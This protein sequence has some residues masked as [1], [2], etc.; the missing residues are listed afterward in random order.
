METN[1]SFPLSMR[2]PMRFCEWDEFCAAMLAC[3]C[4]NVLVG[5]IV[6]DG[7]G[8]C[9][10]SR[11]DGESGCAFSSEERLEEGAV[12]VEEREDEDAAESIVESAVTVEAEAKGEL[13]PKKVIPASARRGAELRANA[14][15]RADLSG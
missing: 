14:A 9:A 4:A 13:R 5:G 3:A 11:C 15:R 12:E 7:G 6:G 1:S 2:W 10:F 8:E